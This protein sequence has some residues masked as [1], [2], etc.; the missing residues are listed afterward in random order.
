MNRRAWESEQDRGMEF[1]AKSNGNDKELV[2]KFYTF[3]GRMH[4]ILGHGLS[5]SEA[6]V[7]AVK[8]EVFTPEEMIRLF[9]ITAMNEI[10]ERMLK[11]ELK[12]CLKK[13]RN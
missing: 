2:Q 4:S 7:L 1:W 6:V 3:W 5:W 12:R 8:S 13:W 10:Q 9:G 11:N